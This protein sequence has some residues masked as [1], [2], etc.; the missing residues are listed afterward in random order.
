MEPNN[1]Q[2]INTSPSGQPIAPQ[3]VATSFPASA[4]PVQQPAP[5]PIL[6]SV[7]ESPKGK[8]NK[9]TVLLIILL[10][11][12]IGMVIYVLFAKNQMNNAQKAATG[13][14][15]VVIPSPSLAPTLAPEEDLEV[16]SPEADLLDLETDVKS[17]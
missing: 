16:S 13:N 1:N 8:N 10:L 2:P 7:P 17:L 9:V 5:S 4:P 3:P 14:S 11:L 12:A 15:S 6:T